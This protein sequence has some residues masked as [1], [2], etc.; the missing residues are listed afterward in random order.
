M[1]TPVVDFVGRALTSRLSLL[2][3]LGLLWALGHSMNVPMQAQSQDR[4]TIGSKNF[5]ESRVLAELFA[6]LIETHTELQVERQFNLG[7]TG[8][9]FEAVR[10]GSI[11]L[12]PEYTGTG[13]TALLK[14]PVI[15][16]PDAAF[17]RVKSAFHEK[18]QLA[19]MRPLGFNNTY[20]MVMR[21]DQAEAL[22]L[23]K[24]SDLARVQDRSLQFGFTHEFLAR[25]DGWPGLKRLYNL[26]FGEDQVRGLEHGLAYSALIEKQI[27]MID[28]YSTDGKISKYP[29]TIL[30]DDKRYFP[31]Y[32]AA[33]LIRE[34]TLAQHPQLEEILNSLDHE[35]SDDMMQQLNYRVEEEGVSLKTVARDF[36]IEK[37][38]ISADQVEAV[39]ENR[40]NSLSAFFWSKRQRLLKLLQQH[41]TLTAL[42]VGIAALLGIPMGIAVARYQPA[43]RF[44]LGIAG[45]LQTIPS[46]ALL[47]FL[48]PFIGT[49]FVPALIALS[50]Y[51]LLPIVRNTYTGMLEVPAQ[52][53]EAAR[54][55]GLTEAQVL[56][57]IELPLAA[58]I[59]MA[60]IRTA[61]V[62]AIGTA[63]LAAFIGA[64]GLG[65]P[66][67][68]GLSLKS[69]NWILLGVIPAA[70][71]ALIAD[72]LLALLE[73]ALAPKLTS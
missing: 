61:T 8:I 7:A 19:W 62:I 37:G 14:E 35:V 47:G 49:G 32:Q 73:R 29:L 11:D 53:K 64:G 9:C 28:A 42:A 41:L 63:T 21:K 10:Q 69:V 5:T 34:D 26:P 36:L 18:Y 65:D 55:I 25:P 68:T 50:L 27:D 20:A 15:Q 71:L 38:K 31:P 45:L 66:I 24:I 2:L 51:A 39:S 43:A 58:T 16:D 52:V 6:T 72:F 23:T 1:Q 59:M 13:L 60:G 40:G 33:A 46:L 17:Q 70:A 67:I 44:V 30:E 54:G 48:V 57:R 12:Y 56:W 22:N 3:L 4:I